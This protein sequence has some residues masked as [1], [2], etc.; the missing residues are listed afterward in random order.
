MVLPP[1]HHL[2]PLHG[3]RQLLARA[4][5]ALCC[6]SVKPNLP[7]GGRSHYSK[8][9]FQLQEL[10]EKAGHELQTPSDELGREAGDLSW[11]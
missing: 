2:G 9:G 1:E 4:V 6:V 10:S 3:E 11:C 5:S 8:D 7:P